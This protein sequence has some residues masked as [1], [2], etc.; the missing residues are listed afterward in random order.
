[1]TKIHVLG[2]YL[3]PWRTTGLCRASGLG[4]SLRRGAASHD[5]TWC[6]LSYGLLCLEGLLTLLGLELGLLLCHF[7]LLLQLLLFSDVGRVGD[8]R[9]RGWVDLRGL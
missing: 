4:L 3:L 7:L 1:M 9:P 5:P 8:L 6:V 2:T